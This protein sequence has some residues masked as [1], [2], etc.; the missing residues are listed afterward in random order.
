MTASVYIGISKIQSILEN[1]ISWSTT[2]HITPMRGCSLPRQMA[3]MMFKPLPG[4]RNIPEIKKRSCNYSQ[5][6]YNKLKG[7]NLVL[8]IIIRRSQE[9]A[10]SRHALI[11]NSDS[12]HVFAIACRMIRM[13]GGISTDDL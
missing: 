11:C 9:R 4:F 2:A 13:K 8:R 12:E 6:E 3:G 5:N 10:F 7:I 1:C